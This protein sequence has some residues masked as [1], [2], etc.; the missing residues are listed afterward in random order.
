MELKMNNLLY[1][2]I[3]P[4]IEGRKEELSSFKEQISFKKRLKILDSSPQK[5]KNAENFAKAGGLKA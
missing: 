2:D 4:K 5:S 1:K 3:E